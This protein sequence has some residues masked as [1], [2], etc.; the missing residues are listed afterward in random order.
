MRRT[1]YPDLVF[2]PLY[3]MVSGRAERAAANDMIV[4]YSPSAK[5][6][7]VGADK[8]FDTADFVADMR[9]F[10][11]STLQSQITRIRAAQGDFQ[12]PARAVYNR[13]WRGSPSYNTV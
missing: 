2:N 12:Q 5:R 3:P 11:V 4:R 10:N 13:R 8:G 9:A 7:T 1:R 6:I